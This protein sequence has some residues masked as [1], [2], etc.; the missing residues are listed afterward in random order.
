MALWTLEIRHK[1]LFEE[2]T[3]LVDLIDDNVLF[4]I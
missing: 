4:F 3:E 1:I 2:L